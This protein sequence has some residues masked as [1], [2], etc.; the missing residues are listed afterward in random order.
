[1]AVDRA[2]KVRRTELQTGEKSKKSRGAENFAVFVAVNCS[3]REQRAE[4]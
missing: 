1:M 2:E 3:I 4:S